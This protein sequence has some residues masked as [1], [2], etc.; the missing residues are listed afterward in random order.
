MGLFVSLCLS[1]VTVKI[2]TE[3]TV[4]TITLDT[5]VASISLVSLLTSSLVTWSKQH[6]WN[7]C[8]RVKGYTFLVFR[9]CRTVPL[10]KYSSF[11]GTKRFITVFTRFCCWSLCWSIGIKF[12]FTDAVYLSFMLIL[13]YRLCLVIW[14]CK[15]FQIKF[16]TVCIS[17]ASHFLPHADYPFHV[18]KQSP[19]P[20]TAPWFYHK[21]NFDPFA[22]PLNKFEDNSVNHFFIINFCV[23]RA[24]LL[25]C[26]PLIW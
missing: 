20:L 22:E 7:L 13:S 1:F 17:H 2:P 3:H 4:T 11:Y 10:R 9:N 15:V 5:V 16:R 6:V 18:V 25:G 23:E 14:S 8:T 12:T 24:C 21:I 26:W 19:W